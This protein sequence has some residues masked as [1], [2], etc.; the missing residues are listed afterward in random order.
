MLELSSRLRYF[1]RMRKKSKKVQAGD[2]GAD[3]WTTG[4]FHGWGGNDANRG[5]AQGILL[6]IGKRSAEVLPGHAAYWSGML[7]EV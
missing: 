3:C 7:Y 2:S 6:C 4:R 1:G 5:H